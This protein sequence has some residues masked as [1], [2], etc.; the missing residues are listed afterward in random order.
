M[1]RLGFCSAVLLL[2]FAASW[3]P[4]D[5]P[6]QA[7]GERAKPMPSNKLR[8]E[9]DVQTIRAH[10]DHQVLSLVFSPDGKRLASGGA[11]ETLKVWDV[12]TGKQVLSK[13]LQGICSGVA[14]SSDGKRVASACGAADEHVTIWDGATGA[15]VRSL[16]VRGATNSVAFSLD[17]K[18]LAAGGSI[19][20]KKE[21][22][23][24]LT[25]VGGT[26]KTWE[27]ATGK[28]VLSLDLRTH[29]VT[30]VAFSPD[31]K[32]LAAG[33]GE[34]QEHRGEIILWDVASGKEIRTIRSQQKGA[35]IVAF[36]PDGKRLA[37]GCLEGG[38]KLWDPTSGKDV[39]TFGGRK[40]GA[41]TLAFS[42]DGKWLAS[43]TGEETVKV[44][45]AATGEEVLCLKPPG[46]K[47]DRFV[48]SV[49]FSPD[50]KRL[51]AG[52]RDGVVR[53]WKLAE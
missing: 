47:N 5:L 21:G 32:W 7:P 8:V 52:D 36:S 24:L 51:A 46:E 16:A 42:P 22:Q 19:L 49:A 41:T 4:V 39:L 40:E 12:A 9:D 25:V 3:Y 10:A 15:E 26:V 48:Y 37:A 50:G 6:A 18:Q 45:T 53:V 30:S 33:T 35:L 2:G 44:W 34:V 38:L 28:L 14:F 23:D 13:R 20:G 11:D 27:A 17:G 1:S 31:G 43:A 29:F